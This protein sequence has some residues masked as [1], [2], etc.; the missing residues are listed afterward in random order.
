LQCNFRWCR[1]HRFDFVLQ[2]KKRDKLWMLVALKVGRMWETLDLSFLIPSHKPDWYDVMKD[3]QLFAVCVVGFTGVILTLLISARQ[4]RTARTETIEHQRRALRVAV[5][6]ELKQIKAGLSERLDAIQDPHLA[7]PVL[8]APM[9]ATEIFS[10]VVKDIGL[11]RT[12]QAQAVILAY[13]SVHRLDMNLSFH[14]E[15]DAR[16][17]VRVEGSTEQLTS[18]LLTTAIQR[19]Q[20]ALDTFLFDVRRRRGMRTKRA[21]R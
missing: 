21:V 13:A 20:L 3:F 6:E 17:Y 19:V 12:D 10:M 15:T 18:I 5:V 9:L 4:A 14:N 1:T 16:G 7:A 2:F 11:L 8:L